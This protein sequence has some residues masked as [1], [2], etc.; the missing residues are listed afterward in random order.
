MSNDRVHIVCE[1]CGAWKMLLKFFPSD[2]STRD[3]GI[4]EWL[5]A[6]GDCHD[7]ILES[8]LHGDPGFRLVAESSYDFKKLDPSLQNKVPE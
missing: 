5:D 2:L 3:N 8:D 6:H 4:L 7:H 1:G